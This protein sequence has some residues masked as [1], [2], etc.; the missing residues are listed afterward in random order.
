[1]DANWD[2]QE[3]YERWIKANE[4]A[5]VYIIAC[6][7]DVLAKKHESLAMAKVIMDSFRELFGQP[8]WSFRHETNKHICTKRMK[9]GTSVREHV[10]DMMLHFNIIEVNGSPIY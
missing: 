9:D 5:R 2:V 6:I 4:K 8:S 3:A 7:Y 10:L 1:M